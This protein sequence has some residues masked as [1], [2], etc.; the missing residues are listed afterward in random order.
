MRKAEQK[1]LKRK[2]KRETQQRGGGG[3]RKEEPQ[4][5]GNREVCTKIGLEFTACVSYHNY[6]N[7]ALCNIC[8]HN[9]NVSI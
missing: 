7:Y 2:T 4:D 5:L 3:K 8:V 9:V 1:H 6:R